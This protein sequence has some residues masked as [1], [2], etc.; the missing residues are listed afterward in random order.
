MTKRQILVE[1]D[2]GDETCGK[3]P[4]W[5][6]LYGSRTARCTLFSADLK[7]P[8]PIATEL[9][10]ARTFR[11]EECKAAEDGL[12]ILRGAAAVGAEAVSKGKG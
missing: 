7:A 6:P 4:V 12:L 5:D 1:I 3:C 9:M 2:C 8:Y 10:R 11:C